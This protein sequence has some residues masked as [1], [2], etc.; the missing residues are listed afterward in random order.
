MFADVKN[1]EDIQTLVDLGLTYRQSKILLALSILGEATINAVSS[2]A[3]MDRA[4]VY[5]T[6]KQLRDLKLVQVSIKN[7]VTFEGLPLNDAVLLL[8]ECN[9][10][11]YN[12]AEIKAKRFLRKHRQR[13]GI[14]PN[15]IESQFLLVPGGKL[16]INKIGE[17]ADSTKITHDGI[18]YF[19]DIQSRADF[20]Y[21][22]FTELLLNGIKIRIIV[23]FENG[24]KLPSNFATL[25]K[26]RHF[27]IRKAK[28]KPEVTFSI[29]DKEKVF[30][31]VTPKISE[32]MTDGLF[33]DNYAIVGLIQEYFELIWERSEPIP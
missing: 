25:L 24:E 28:S 11:K 6:M 7:P 18:L 14:K 10:N 26:N 32:P 29:W 2:A 5:R 19:K 9:K 3:K 1:T 33:V 16:T 21:N 27:K 30:L 17:L 8:M 15:T 4:N 13:F 22:L 20:F 31:T 12:D 23:C